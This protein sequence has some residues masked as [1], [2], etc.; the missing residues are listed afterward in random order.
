MKYN[1]ILIKIDGEKN[2]REIFPGSP[3]KWIDCIHEFFLDEIRH[4]F[5]R[6]S[7]LGTTI[8]LGETRYL[9]LKMLRQEFLEKVAIKVLDLRKNK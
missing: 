8:Y 6:Q 7:R 4:V 5:E 1:R 3:D 2:V 9:E